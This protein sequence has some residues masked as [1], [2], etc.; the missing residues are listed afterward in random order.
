MHSTEK[1]EILEVPIILPSSW[2]KLLIA[3]YP[4]LLCGD[5]GDGSGANLGEQ[6]EAFWTCFE[7]FQPGHVCFEKSKDQLRRTLP[8]ALHGDEGRY[9]K[10]GNFM[11]CS[12]ECMLGPDG[13]K[14]RSNQSKRPCACCADPVLTRY[15]EIGPAHQQDAEFNHLLNLAAGQHVNDSGQEFLSKYLAFGMSSLVYKKDKTLL[16]KAFDII[17]ADLSMLHTTG[18]DVGGQT[19]YASTCGIKGDLKFFHQLGN[20]T[21]SYYNSG[22]KNNHAICSLCMAGHD[23]V[24][25]EDLSDSAV[26]MDT[27]FLSGRGLV[28]THHR[29]QLYPFNLHVQK[30]FSD[31]IFFIATSVGQEE[32]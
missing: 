23:G 18:I 26:W 27:Q 29:W 8:L 1:G 13:T 5:A 4:F 15:G 17:S 11:V 6:L 7:Y 22:T 3:E 16:K 25:F 2:L 31:L 20:L 28:I 21:R 10:K 14:K 9:L 12:V 19:F 32:N 30:V 24:L